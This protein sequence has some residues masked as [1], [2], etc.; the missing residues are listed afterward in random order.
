MPNL[1]GSPTFGTT[2]QKIEDAQ[3]VYDPFNQLV[4]QDSGENLDNAFGSQ[5]NSLS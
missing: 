1:H 5:I 3:Q 2:K 4:R